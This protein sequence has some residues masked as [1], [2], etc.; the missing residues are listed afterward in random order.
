MYTLLLSISPYSSSSLLRAPIAMGGRAAQLGF[1]SPSRREGGW[2]RRSSTATGEEKRRGYDRRCL[3]VE[4]RTGS[5]RRGPSV[6]IP[7]R[8]LRRTDWRGRVLGRK[9][10]A[11]CVLGGAEALGGDVASP[12]PPPLRRLAFPPS[13]RREP[14][15][16]VRVWAAPDRRGW[17]EEDVRGGGRAAAGKEA[18]AVALG[19]RGRG[20]EV[21]RRPGS[22]QGRRR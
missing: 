13:L 6:A 21:G 22:R 3:V 14:V 12:K 7:P 20:E 2:M 17:K 4:K 19:A 1:R 10:S 15:R 8:W 5:R 9:N 11:V 16:R 18:G